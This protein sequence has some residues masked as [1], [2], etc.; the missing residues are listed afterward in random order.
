MVYYGILW[1]TMAYHDMV[2]ELQQIRRLQL[3]ITKSTRKSTSFSFPRM[4]LNPKPKPY[5]LNRV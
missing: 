4:P 1:Y 5:T 3:D 2:L